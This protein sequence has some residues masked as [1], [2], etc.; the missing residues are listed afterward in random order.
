[1]TRP[2]ELIL[3]RLEKVSSNKGGSRYKALCPAHADRSPSLSI[4][5]GDDGRVLLHCFSGY[6]VVAIV[7]SVNLT[8][9]ELFCVDTGSKRP[10]LVPGVS[11]RELTAAIEFEKTILYI[12]KTDEAK[13][14]CISTNDSQRAQLALQR[15]AKVKGLL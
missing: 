4:C 5:E 15:V 2:I 3:S 13:G 8:M 12:A 14:R 11:R 9:A 6:S 7:S 1:M 10:P